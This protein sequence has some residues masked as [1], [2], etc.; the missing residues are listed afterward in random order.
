[1]R[2]VAEDGQFSSSQTGLLP[3][4]SILPTPPFY[5]RGPT[6]RRCVFTSFIIT[7]GPRAF[8]STTNPRPIGPGPCGICA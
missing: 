6:N 8:F 3:N 2:G 5:R 7:P 1:M 4:V